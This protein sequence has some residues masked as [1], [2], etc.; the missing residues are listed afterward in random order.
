MSWFKKIFGSQSSQS[1]QSSQEP[2]VYFS[3]QKEEEEEKM[4]T[5]KFKDCNKVESTQDDSQSSCCSW[6]GVSQAIDIEGEKRSWDKSKKEEKW[7]AAFQSQP[8]TQVSTSCQGAS[9]QKIEEENDGN[10]DD[11]YDQMQTQTQ[12]Q[13]ETEKISFYL[14][15]GKYMKFTFLF[16]KKRTTY[17]KIILVT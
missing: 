12:T 3:K 16:R 15:L 4:T 6:S 11:D 5:S 1:S 8:S 17:K 13:D 7:W 2:K 10:D 9:S 14:K